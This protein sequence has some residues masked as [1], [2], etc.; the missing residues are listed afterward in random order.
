MTYA[1]GIARPAMIAANLPR[2]GGA[3]HGRRVAD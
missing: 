1:L 3:V 2:A